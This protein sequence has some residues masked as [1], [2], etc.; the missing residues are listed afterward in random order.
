MSLFI[1]YSSKGTASNATLQFPTSNK[2]I[3]MLS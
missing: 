1:I 3:V 2:Y